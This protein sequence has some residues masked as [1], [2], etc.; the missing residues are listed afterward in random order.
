MNLMPLASATKQ[1]YEFALNKLKQE[2]EAI[3]EKILNVERYLYGAARSILDTAPD[4]PVQATRKKRKLSAKAKSA[5]SAAQ[6][7]RWKEYAAKKN[8]DEPVTAKATKKK[9]VKKAV[10]KAAKKA[11]KKMGNSD[12]PF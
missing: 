2:R 9:S 8:A 1:I 12:V 4:V 10:K 5:I 7:K 6:V 11:A 3:E